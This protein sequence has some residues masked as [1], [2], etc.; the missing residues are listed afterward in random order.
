[1]TFIFNYEG[2]RLIGVT[3]RQLSHG[4][5]NTRFVLANSFFTII[6]KLLPKPQIRNGFFTKWNFKHLFQKLEVHLF[7]GLSI[8][9]FCT[10]RSTN[11]IPHILHPQMKVPC[12]MRKH[13]FN[14][15]GKLVSQVHTW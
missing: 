6:M 4:F 2:C 15:N 11:S 10:I 3:K 9:F 14:L 8:V 7:S 5:N 12:Y 13:I 1:M